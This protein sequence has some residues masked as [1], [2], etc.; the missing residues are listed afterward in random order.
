MGLM[1]YSYALCYAWGYFPDNC[2]GEEG[3]DLVIYSSHVFIT[4]LWVSVDGGI[5]GRWVFAVDVVRRRLALRK[6]PG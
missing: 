6:A 4:L 3:L 2:I 1:F 5:L